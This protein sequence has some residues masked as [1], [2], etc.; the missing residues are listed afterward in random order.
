ML[1]IMILAAPVYEDLD[2]PRYDDFSG[3]CSDD[4]VLFEIILSRITVTSWNEKQPFL[5]LYI[6]IQSE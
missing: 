4:H 5:K 3:A 6:Q 2:G 1:I